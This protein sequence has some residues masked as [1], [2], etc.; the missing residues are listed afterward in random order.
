[1]RK[2]KKYKINLRTRNIQ[3]LLKTISKV[4]EITPQIE[5]AVKREKD[6]ADRIISSAAIYD[7][8]DREKVNFDLG[9]EMPEN[10]VAATFYLVTIGSEIEREIRDVQST[11]ENI[12]AKILHSIGLD[13]LDQSANFITKLINEEAK[14]EDCTLTNQYKLTS[15]AVLDNVFKIIDSEKIG[16]KLKNNKTFEPQYSSCGVIFW[17]PIKKHAKRVKS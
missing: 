14:Q 3:Q 2:I 8:V 15:F 7:T 17:V 16:V 12:L 4:S 10:W 13:A 6:H 9:I 5:E 11:E 1:M